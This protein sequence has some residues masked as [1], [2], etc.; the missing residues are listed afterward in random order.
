V[1]SI[2]LALA[3]LAS[4]GDLPWQDLAFSIE[5]DHSI[6]SDTVTVCRVRVVNRGGHTWPGRAVRFEARALEAGTVMARE[7]GRFGLSIPP[8]GTLETLISFQGLYD[9]FEVHPVFKSPGDPESRSH[10]GKRGKSP[11]KKRKSG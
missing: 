5:K 1:T 11:G 9:R 7:R 3:V 6:S 2:V 10:R 4:P 8:H